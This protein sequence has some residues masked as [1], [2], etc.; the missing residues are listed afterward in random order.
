MGPEANSREVLALIFRCFSTH[1][2]H[3]Q[4]RPGGT[5]GAC[6]RHLPLNDT[7][8]PSRYLNYHYQ[9]HQYHGAG[10]R[11][12]R[13][14]AVGEIELWEL[15][16]DP[17]G[18]SLTPRGLELMGL[19][20][21]GARASPPGAPGVRHPGFGTRAAPLG[22]RSAPWIPAVDVMPVSHTLLFWEGASS[23]NSPGCH[24]R[25]LIR[26]LWLCLIFIQTVTQ[27]PEA[28]MWMGAAWSLRPTGH[29]SPILIPGTA[30]MGSP[31]SL[32]P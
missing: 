19:C 2:S 3:C 22:S 24:C 23:A 18:V 28:S 6:Q 8:L 4:R 11:P 7:L 15:L 10:P 32:S 29:G 1:G 31:A 17:S 14:Q 20:P 5:S 30:P 26:F 9:Y 21:T 12:P 16:G 27:L 13:P 25:G